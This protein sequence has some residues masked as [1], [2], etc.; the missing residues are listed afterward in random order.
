ML[1]KKKLL[2]QLFDFQLESRGSL[3]NINYNYTNKKI[4]LNK[5]E[6]FVLN[7]SKNFYNFSKAL[8][9]LDS[10]LKK[11]GTVLF[12]GGDERSSVYIKNLALLNNQPYIVSK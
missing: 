4:V 3:K 10:V 6:F 2:Q 7:N 9:V 12:V 5:K 1:K 8:F 11:R